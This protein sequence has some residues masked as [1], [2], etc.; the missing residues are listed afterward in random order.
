MEK[1]REQKRR[2]GRGKVLFFDENL[3]SGILQ[4]LSSKER[5]KFTYKD[6]IGES[7]FVILFEGEEVE[8]WYENRR[9]RVKRSGKI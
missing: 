4:P 9:I 6:V 3:G 2:R 5:I 8:F 1:K 7:G